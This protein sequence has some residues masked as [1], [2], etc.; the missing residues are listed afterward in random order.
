M[1][2]RNFFRL[3]KNRAAGSTQ[4]HA[5]TR[6]QVRSEARQQQTEEM[7]EINVGKQHCDDGE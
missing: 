3:V 1:Q 2:L 5:L 6:W 4:G 7:L